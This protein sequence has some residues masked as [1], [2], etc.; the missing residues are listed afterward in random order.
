M[1]TSIHPSML[2]S[3]LKTVMA[4]PE[5]MSWYENFYIGPT[6]SLKA[7]PCDGLFQDLY[8]CQKRAPF[9][10]RACKLFKEDFLECI[11]RKKQAKINRVQYFCKIVSSI[12]IERKTSY[13]S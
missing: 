5:E 3:D 10:L 7:A 2:G 13:Y 11:F 6:S 9:P 8:K 12:I 1:G 4:T